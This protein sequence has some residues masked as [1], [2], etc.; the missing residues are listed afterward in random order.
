MSDTTAAPAPAA[1]AAPAPAPAASPAPAP[2]PAAPAPAPAAP[3]PAPAAPASAPAAQVVFEPTGDAKLDLALSFV[4]KLGIDGE[5]PGIK[6]AEAG[7]FSILKATLAGLGQQ[8][9]GWEQYMALGEEAVGARKAAA[10][11]K[12]KADKAAIVSAVGSEEAW[13]TVQAWATANA[14]PAEREAVNAALAAGGIAAKAMALYLKQ[15][16]DGAAGTTVVPQSAV[17]PAATTGGASGPGSNGPLSPREYA[18][19]VA[20]LNMQLRGRIDGSPQYAALQAR[21]A[22]W[23]G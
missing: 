16:H 15:L 7:D 4:A 11:A 19:A 21:R 12:A 23:R 13:N 8:A 18:A 22:A 6:A 3:A 1:P 5:H 10:E 9:A 17:N 14:E 2:V 20:E